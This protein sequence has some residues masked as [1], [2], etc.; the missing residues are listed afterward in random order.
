MAFNRHQALAN[1][2]PTAVLLA[3]CIPAY[4]SDFVETNAQEDNWTTSLSRFR[5]RFKKKCCVAAV[6]SDCDGSTPLGALIAL[7]YKSR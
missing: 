1:A 2:L 7:T 4:V 6:L 5:C 3:M